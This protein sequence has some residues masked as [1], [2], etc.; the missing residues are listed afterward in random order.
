MSTRRT[1]SAALHARRVAS[2][3]R[4]ERWA[5]LLDTAVVVPGTG[6][7]LGLDAVVGLLP[8]IGDLISALLSM[9]MVVEA[10]RVRAPL[11]VWLRM[12]LNIGIDFVIGLVPV[13][14]DVGDVFYR[15]NTRNVRLLRRWLQA[16]T[17]GES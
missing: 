4:L 12:C 1:E 15:A 7:R 6:I 9:V 10:L 11:W 16:S 8:G 14:G 2:L 17:R 3:Q 5:T 13:A